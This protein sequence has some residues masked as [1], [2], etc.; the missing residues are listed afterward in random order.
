MAELHAEVPAG[1]RDCLERLAAHCPAVAVVRPRPTRD[2]QDIAIVGIGCMFPQSPESADVLAEH[3][4]RLQRDSRGAA[5]P[6]GGPRIIIPPI[7][8]APDKVNSKWGAFL[9]DVVFDPLKYVIPPASLASIEPIQLLALEV[10]WQALEDAGYHG[11]R[12]YAAN[13][14]R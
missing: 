14:R 9:E 5:R 2:D 8:P 6:A 12:I 1:S 4:P 7:G 11:A 3:R 13:G 10:A